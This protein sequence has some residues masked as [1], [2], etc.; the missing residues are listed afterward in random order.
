MPDKLRINTFGGRSGPHD[1]AIKQGFY[2]AE[3]LDVERTATPSSKAQMQELVDGVWDIVH[4]NADNV[5]W[6]CEDNGADLLLVLSTPSRPGQNFVVR[7][8]IKGYEDLRGKTIAVDASESGF[9]T[10]LRMLL[11]EHGL[12]LEGRDF[13]FLEVGNTEFRIEAIKDGRC[14]GGMIGAGQTAALE[15][16]HVLD[17]IN[18][19]YTHYAA[20]VVVQREWAEQNPD[21]LLRYLRAHL[22]A[23]R[24][25]ARQADPT[26]AVPPFEW[27]GMRQMMETR[28]SGGWLRGPA[29]PHRFATQQYYDQAVAGLSS[30]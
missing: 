21:L 14:A 9:V 12:T 6:W 15:G 29:D 1:I 10:P 2:A 26:A 4:T 16:C 7:P 18:R 17:S 30:T 11:S 3:N 19:L 27:E 13:T 8:E 28:R 20:T 25:Q 22:H 23:Q 24:W 5:Y